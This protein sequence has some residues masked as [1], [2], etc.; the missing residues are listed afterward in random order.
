MLSSLSPDGLSRVSA[1]GS[2]RVRAYSEPEATPWGVYVY[3]A[4]EGIII[5]EGYHKNEYK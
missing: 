1:V 4:E 5:R 3:V 2:G